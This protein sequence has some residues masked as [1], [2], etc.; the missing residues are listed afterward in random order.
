MKKMEKT[1]VVKPDENGIKL[2]VE[3]LKNGKVICFKTDTI[4][5]FSCDATNKVAC[6]KILNA[7]GRDGKPFILLAKNTEVVCSFADNIS[8]H[9]QKLM[10]KFWPGPLSII[11][12]S[13]DKFST[14]VTAGS[15]TIAFRVPKDDLCQK[16]LSELDFPIT[17]TSANISGQQSLN[18]PSQIFDEFDGK[19]D[20]I[21]DSGIAT[22]F[23]PSTVVNV[24]SENIEVLREGAIKSTDI[25]EVTE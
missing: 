14:E 3:F 21:I 2:A 15:K 10:E 13:T 25:L 12:N 20:L 16:I 24:A 1:I 23:L 19:I 7:K 22:S 8:K 11:V 17:S 6:Q 9:A 4:Y 18:N 5:G